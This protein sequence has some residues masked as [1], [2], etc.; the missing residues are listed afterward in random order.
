MLLYCVLI[1]KSNHPSSKPYEPEPAQDF[2]DAYRYQLATMAYAAGVTHYHRMPVMRSLFKPLI[3]R[4]IHKIL[5]REVWGNWYLT[6][7]SE[8]VVEPDIKEL[9]KPWADPIVQENVMYS[10]HLLLITS[11]YAMLLIMTSLRSPEKAILKEMERNGWVGVCCEPNIVFVVCNQFPLIAMRYND[12]RDG[13]KVIDGVLDKYRAALESKNMIANT[14]LFKDWLVLK[15][16]HTR[17]AKDCGFTA[18]AASFIDTWNSDFVKSGYKAHSSGFITN[19]NGKFELQ[20]PM[21]ADEQGQWTHMDPFSENSAIGY[22]R[23]NVEDGQKKMWEAP[24][25]KDVIEKMPWV[26][27]LDL[28]SEVDCLRGIWDASAQWLVTTLREWADRGTHVNFAVRNLPSNSW[29]LYEPRAG[30]V[31]RELANGVEIR[32]EAAVEALQEIDFLVS[33]A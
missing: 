19:I 12:V 29:F 25:T 14:E 17:G 22:A 33:K 10:A 18:W 30:V 8:S 13:T 21:V 7:Q 28:S 16:D 2:L 9:R 26:D 15:Q 1:P 3:R 11:I 23:L 6:S 4:L 5:R 32:V 27:G 20:H 24:W 31:R